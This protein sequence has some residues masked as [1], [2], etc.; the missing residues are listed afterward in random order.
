[1]QVLQSYLYDF[2]INFS[3]LISNCFYGTTQSE[4]ECQN[5]KMKLYQTGKNM[6]LIKYNYQTF[7]FLNFPLAEVSK[8][9]LSNQMLYR[10]YMNAN[11][12]PNIAVDLMDC[13]SYY[14]KDEILGCYCDGCQIIMP[15]LYQE[16]NYMLLQYI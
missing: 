9:I 7:F 6:P 1:M 3:S 2:Q 10:K 12:N 13:F 11:V 15:K 4:F 8:Y 14:Q 5:C 16:P